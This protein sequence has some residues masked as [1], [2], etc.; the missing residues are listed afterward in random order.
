MVDFG[1][2]MIALFLILI[3]LR[4]PVYVALL[5]PPLVYAILFDMEL[6]VAGQVISRSMNSFSLLAV[7]L[8]VF[9]GA[10]MNNGGIADKIFTFANNIVGHL[11]GGLA[12]VNIFTSLIF[13]GMSG[14]A[15]A[16]I[17]GIGSVL[18]DTMRDNGYSNSYSAALTSAA[19]TIGP[20]FPPSIPLIIY[21]IL[22]RT[23]VVDLLLAGLV[24]A[25][26]LFVLLILMTIFLSYRRDFPTY[27]EKPGRRELV[28]SF[29]VGLPALGAPVVL[30]YGMLSGIVGVTEIAVATL[31]YMLAVNTLIY[32]N[33]NPKYIWDSA[34]ETAETTSVILILLAS[35]SLFSR[36]ITLEGTANTFGSALLGVSS[37][38]L[39]LLIL[40]NV[41]LLILGL[42][43][44]PLSAMLITIP[45]VV[46]TLTQ[47]GVDPVH[48]GVIMVFNLMLGLLTPPL[49]LSVYLASDIAD[50]EIEDTLFELT[51]YYVVLMLT[52]VLI[53]FVPALSL[54]VPSL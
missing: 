28:R 31:V 23:S 53:T 42:F 37:D 10:V 40:V 33:R 32:G 18:M 3:L 27:G 17:G 47:A 41:L 35:A 36:V 2:V 39:V 46:P 8:F 50:A 12:H 34:V 6:F 48:I 30:I 7:P 9:V 14:S 11:T 52:L 45:L 25:L 26:V 13:S 54:W 51:P 21:G 20:L 19:A 5:T 29:V 49:G 1:L 16:D 22:S 4:V 24:P 15:L 44:E 38:P 43:L